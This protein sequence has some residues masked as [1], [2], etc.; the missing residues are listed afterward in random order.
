MPFSLS[1]SNQALIITP[2]LRLLFDLA[3]A[4][5]RWLVVYC[6]GEYRAFHHPVGHFDFAWYV[7]AASYAGKGADS[8]RSQFS[9]G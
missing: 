4:V 5:M 8:G 3:E 2:P 9:A 7:P 6:D 1:H